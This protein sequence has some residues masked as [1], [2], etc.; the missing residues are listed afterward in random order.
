MA[1][2]GRVHSGRSA[3]LLEHIG[4]SRIFRIG[5]LF[6][7]NILDDTPSHVKYANL[8]IYFQ[9]LKKY[10]TFLREPLQWGEPSLRSGALEWHR[11]ELEMLLAV[12][13]ALRSGLNVEETE[14]QVSVHIMTII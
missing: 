7:P 6:S 13:E 14:H 4:R 12:R 3:K 9:D 8:H 11:K 5:E 2:L 10:E 1:S